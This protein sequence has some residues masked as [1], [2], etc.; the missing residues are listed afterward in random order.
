MSLL[1]DYL[2]GR[3]ETSLGQQQQQLRSIE[4][5]LSETNDKLET[6]TERIDAAMTWAQRL[7][8][9]VLALLGA[10]GL[11]LSPNQLGEMLAH[12]LKVPR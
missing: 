9:M 10:V 6:L 3:I 4:S 11:N 1:H 12:L 2:L 8:L 7:A 5:E